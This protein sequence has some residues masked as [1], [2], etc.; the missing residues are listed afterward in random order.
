MM[1]GGRIVRRSSPQ[2][3]L[4]RLEGL[5]IRGRLSLL[6]RFAEPLSAGIDGL[7]VELPGQACATVDADLGV[8]RHLDHLQHRF[9][10]GIHSDGNFIPQF[11][12]VAQHQ[13]CHI[14]AKAKLTADFSDDVGDPGRI[15]LIGLAS[16]QLATSPSS[17]ST[18]S[19]NFRV[20]TMN[21]GASAWG[22]KKLSICSAMGI[23]A[24]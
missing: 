13:P 23:T 17:Y 3:L 20:F 22:L 19:L 21:I 8:F 2:F 16:G 10:G 14:G 6:S 7:N 4:F 9:A 15:D 1:R 18:R 24:F 11:L 12:D 5:S